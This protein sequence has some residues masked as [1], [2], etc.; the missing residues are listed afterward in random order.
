MFCIETSITTTYCRILT[1]WF[2]TKYSNLL[3]MSTFI[4]DILQWILLMDVW[5]LVYV[6]ITISIYIYLLNIF[7]IR[8]RLKLD[9]WKYLCF[10]YR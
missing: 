3:I 2:H 7:K 9:L 4:H 1:I 8:I 10:L 5:N 6:Y